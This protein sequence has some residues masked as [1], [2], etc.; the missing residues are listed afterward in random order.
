[1]KAVQIGGGLVGQLIA[2]DMMKDFEVTVPTPPGWLPYWR[3]LTSSR[4]GYRDVSA[5]K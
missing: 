5:T 1:M 2:A 4:R 3:T